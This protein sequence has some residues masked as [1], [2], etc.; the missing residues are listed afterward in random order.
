MEVVAG[1]VLER[2][3]PFLELSVVFRLS[4]ARVPG[5]SQVP[6]FYFTPVFDSPPESPLKMEHKRRNDS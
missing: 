5:W 3:A 2:F 4:A 6:A 1:L